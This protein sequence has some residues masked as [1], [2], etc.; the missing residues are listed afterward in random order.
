MKEKL[1]AYRES[2]VLIKLINIHDLIPSSKRCQK[3]MSTK[4]NIRRIKQSLCVNCLN[5]GAE[6]RRYGVSFLLTQTTQD[7][8]YS[9]MES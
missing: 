3:N 6:V 5:D 7:T 1:N 9:I 4:S 2:K 8:L